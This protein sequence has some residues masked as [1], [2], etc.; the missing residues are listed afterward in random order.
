M[1]ITVL[2]SGQDGGLPQAAATHA[3]DA[4][5]RQGLVPERTGP[6]LL[7]EDGD[8]SFLCDVSPDFRVQWWKRTRPPDAI[9]LTHAHV[10]HY[11]G[12]VH[13]GK[14]SMATRPIPVHATGAMLGFLTAHA[15][16]ESLFAEGHLQQA[17]LPTWAGHRIELIPVPHRAEYTDTVAVS[18]D[19]RVLWLPDID[20]WDAWPSAAAVVSSHEVVF[21]D[22]TFWAPDEVPGRRIEDIPHPLVPDTLA[23]FRDLDNRRIL[24]HLNHTN[25]LCDPTSDEHLQV[26]DAGFEVAV[27][28]L[29]IDL[30]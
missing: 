9:A 18:I 29:V 25:P 3:H 1:R 26:H 8:S 7:I 13:F 19:G 14:E 20:G 2:G 4:D 5:A 24:V 27:D 10:G 17:G 12:L 23:S 16:W 30:P 21:L 6:S 15:P 28:G 11:G 22:A